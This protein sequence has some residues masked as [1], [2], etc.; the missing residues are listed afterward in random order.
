M[1]SIHNLIAAISPDVFC[2]KE[3]KSDVKKIVKEAL[4]RGDKDAYIQGAKKAAPYEGVSIYSYDKAKK[5]P[6]SLWAL[7]SPTEQHEIFYDSSSEGL[8]PLYFWLHDFMNSIGITT[9]KITDN[10]VSSPGSGHFSELQGKATQMQQEVSRN[11]GNVNTVIKSILNIV[12]DLKEF[13]LQIKPYEELD[14]K[15]KNEKESAMLTLKQR[16]MDNV[17]I[18]RGQGSINALSAGA[19]DFVTLRDAFMSIKSLDSVDDIDL[20]ERVK[21]ILKQRASEFYSWLKES[22]KALKQR[23]VIE[24]NY[25]KTQYNTVKLYARWLKPYLIA[26]KKLEQQSYDKADLV[27][28]FNT[29]ILQLTLLAEMKYDPEDDVNEGNLPEV[30]TKL[31][32]A[33]KV[34]EYVP[35]FVV[36]LK[37]RG[38]PQ[39]AGQHYIFGG[40]VEIKFTSYALNKQELE[41][42]KDQIK[43]DDIGDIMSLI[44]GATTESLGQLQEDIDKFLEIKK[45]D[46]KDSKNS[47]DTNPFTALFSF[48]KSETKEEKWD[49]SKPI[50]S[51]SDYEKIIRN[52][53]AIAAMEKCFLVFDVYKKSHGMAS[54]DS[55]HEP[56]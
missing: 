28:T 25:L 13:E 46:K 43:K 34:R 48:F 36:E 8:E 19:L 29:V 35:F 56:I 49:I 38:I 11:L 7:K 10:F 21:R 16:W 20:N 9:E 4:E 42:L 40:R 12:Y 54:H 37:F 51:D 33:K 52:Q 41:V 5:D 14:S 17:D 6:F 55:H 2:D 15:N 47:E 24:K 18:K 22:E 23:F 53:S 27:T 30:F 50:K 44:E 39:K 1:V 32:E 26:A 45:K 31:K 3:K